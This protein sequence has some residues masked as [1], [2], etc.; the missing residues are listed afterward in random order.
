MQHK[1]TVIPSY[2]NWL[3][4]FPVSQVSFQEELN[5]NYQIANMN[6][7]NN[8]VL[9]KYYNIKWKDHQ[10]IKYTSTTNHIYGKH[11]L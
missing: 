11:K 10:T 8:N 3:V 9:P 1:V 2:L 4:N 6:G 7:Y 5:I